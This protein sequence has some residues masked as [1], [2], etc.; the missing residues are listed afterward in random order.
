[1]NTENK[2]PRKPVARRQRGARPGRNP[3]PLLRQPRQVRGQLCFIFSDTEQKGDE[4]I[5]K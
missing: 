2:Q 4:S 1:M 3:A 5:K